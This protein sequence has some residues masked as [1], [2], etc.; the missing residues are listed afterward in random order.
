MHLIINIVGEIPSEIGKFPMLQVFYSSGNKLSGRFQPAILNLSSLV[1]LN[2]ASNYLNGELPSNLGSSLPNLQM[3]ELYN[4][5]CKGNFPI[6][7]VNVSKLFVLDIS[8]NN[9][10]GVVPSSIGKLKELSL[11]NLEFNQFHAHDKQDW[12]FM[13]SLFNCTKL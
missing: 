11:L 6:S 4:N 7:L 8:K 10:T 5:L 2:L 9:F 12:D 13:H 3:F 1:K